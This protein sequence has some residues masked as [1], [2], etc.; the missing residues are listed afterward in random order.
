MAAP[1]IGPMF[2]EAIPGSDGI[3]RQLQWQARVEGAHG[4]DSPRKSCLTPRY[5]TKQNMY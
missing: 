4:E 2:W 1:N 3:S 5:P